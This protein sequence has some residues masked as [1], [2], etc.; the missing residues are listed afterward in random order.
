MTVVLDASAL[1]AMLHNEQGADK[2]EAA[3]LNKAVISTVNWTE[4]IQK[5]IAKNIRVDDLDSELAAVGLSFFSFDMQQAH[6]AGSLWQQTKALGLSLGDRACLAL[7]LH[8]DLPVLTADK[9]WQQ[10]DIGVSILL[11]R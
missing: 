3:L 6:I 2:V 5:A 10:L 4:V 11:I 1:L 9:I 8:L 7:A